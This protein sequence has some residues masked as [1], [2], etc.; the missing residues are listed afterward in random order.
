MCGLQVRDWNDS[1][2][3]CWKVDQSEKQNTR[4]SKATILRSQSDAS[5]DRV[6]HSW[7]ETARQCCSSNQSITLLTEKRIGCYD[8]LV[9]NWRNWRRACISGLSRS[10]RG[11]G[12]TN[13]SHPFVTLSSLLK[14]CTVTRWSVRHFD[15][16]PLCWCTKNQQQRNICLSPCWLTCHR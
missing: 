14:R 8:C 6:S 7:Y 2:R 15:K 5:C 1:R 16:S 11:L 3:S 12:H 10:C 9:R 13:W 4:D